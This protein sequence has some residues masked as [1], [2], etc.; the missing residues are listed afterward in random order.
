[1][2]ITDEIHPDEAFD[3]ATQ[4]K[5]WTTELKAAWHQEVVFRTYVS[6]KPGK[7]KV[8]AEEFVVKD[9]VIRETRNKEVLDEFGAAPKDRAGFNSVGD[10][11]VERHLIPR[12]EI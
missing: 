6:R 2:R 3:Q 7:K 12:I 5:A 11:G 8:I 1:M 10:S 4:A 9:R